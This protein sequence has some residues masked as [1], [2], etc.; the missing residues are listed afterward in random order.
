MSIEIRAIPVGL[1]H[2]ALAP[3]PAVPQARN[4]WERAMALREVRALCATIRSAGG[5]AP[6]VLDVGC[7]TGDRACDFLAEGGWVTAL[8]PSEA[9]LDRL[10]G[11]LQDP[12]WQSRCILVRKDPVPYLRSLTAR[13]TSHFD[14][15]AVGEGALGAGLPEVVG[16]LAS[17]VHPGGYL[18]FADLPLGAGDL[19]RSGAVRGILHASLG[20]LDGFLRGTRRTPT[21]DLAGH[22]PREVR[23]NAEEAGFREIFLGRHNRRRTGF[24]SYVENGPLG[25][26]RRDRAGLTRFTQ[27]FRRE[28]A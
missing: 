3:D 28:R 7:G 17:V 26:L 9:A 6:A 21:G 25:A 8:D 20:I 19:E 27:C 13:T 11:R 18:Y 16:V 5:G 10:L 23:L 4:A 2:A 12:R 14:V 24:A 15:V 22:S 1:P